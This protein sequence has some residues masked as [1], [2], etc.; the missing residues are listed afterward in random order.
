MKVSNIYRYLR[1]I[2]GF[3][4]GGHART[5]LAQRNIFA[6]LLIKGT[7][8]AIGISLVPLTINYLDTTKYGIW[9]TLSSIIGWFGFF[10]L[11]LGHGLRNKFAEAIAN[12]NQKLARVYVSTTYAIII[13]VISIVLLIFYFLNPLLN[14]NLILNVD[15]SLMKD[16]E[17][18]L[19]ALVVFTFF[20]LR[21]IFNLLISILIA[22]QR[23][24]IAS[25]F[26]LFGKII[27]LITIIFLVKF[28]NSSLLYLS[29]SLSSAPVLV[30]FISSFIFFNYRYKKFRPSINFVQLEKAPLLFN[31]GLKFFVIQIAALLLYQTNNVIISQ[32]F[33]S[34][35]VATYN[36]VFT[37]FTVLT[38]G[39]SIFLS[40]FWSAVT[41]A[42]VKKELSWIK[43]SMEKLRYFWVGFSVLG[44]LM[45][46][47]SEFFY[48]IWIGD[49][50][51]IPFILSFLVLIWVLLNLWNN[52]FSNFLNGVG[53]L[54][55]QLLLGILSAVANVPLSVYLGKIYGI[56]GVLI[57]NIIVGLIGAIIYP[58]QYKKIISG[59]AVGLFNK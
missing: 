57:A 58:I 10:D 11:G 49:L 54:K 29:I 24:A 46:I 26:D 9:I 43:S 17:L 4:S 20:C 48:S 41:D 59:N 2:T 31:L 23:P 22:D 42:W 36:I 40:P 45:L 50:V 12:G 8:I 33:G 34:E 55:L 16:S 44:V 27:A 52:L 6:S 56:E 21:F 3:G 37:Y 19:I 5:R 13:I 39:F 28:T 18:S 1:N 25:L 7:N 51:S 38:M 35:M 47:F 53:K 30:L 14:W 15:S 32:L